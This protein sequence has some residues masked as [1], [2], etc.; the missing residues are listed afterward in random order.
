MQLPKC[1]IATCLVT[2]AGNEKVHSPMATDAAGPAP[3]SS[4]AT[5]WTM[6]RGRVME[7]LHPTATVVIGDRKVKVNLNARR[8]TAQRIM[9]QQ[10]RWRFLFTIC[11]VPSHPSALGLIFTRIPPQRRRQ[12][13][14]LSDEQM[15]ELMMISVFS[16]KVR[17]WPHCR[18]GR[19]C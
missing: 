10:K 12:D 19:V 1:N 7:F 13:C 14:D 18:F 4:T 9:R 16:E 5:W 15:D 6:L 17:A 3:S 8:L 11:V 2:P